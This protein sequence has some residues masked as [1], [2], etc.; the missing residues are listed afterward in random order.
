MVGLLLPN[1]WQFIEAYLAI[2]KLGHIAMPLD[3]T[4]KRLEIEAVL[5]Q[6]PAELIITDDSYSGLLTKFQSKVILFGDMGQTSDAK[7]KDYKALRLPAGQQIAS[8]VFTSGTTGQPK[9][10]PYTHRNHIWNIEVCSK[11]WNWTADDSLLISLPLSHWYGIVMGLSGIIYHGNSLYLQDWFDEQKTLRAL[12]SGQITM[13]T[14]IATIYSLLVTAE[15]D[16]DLS[17]VRLCISGGAALPP[18]VWQQFKDRFGQAILECY[19]SSE[20]G[21]IASNL[22]NERIPGSPGRVLDGVDLKLGPEGE[23]TI[24]SEGVFPGYWQNQSATK[25]AYTADGHWRTG[26]IGQFENGRIILKGRI[27]ERIRRFGYT[28]SPRDVEWALHQS[29]GIQEVYV[30]GVQHPDQANDELVYFVKADL[31]TT[32]ILDY[33]H[34]NLPF[35]WRTENIILVDS[36]PRTKNSKPKLGE[37]NKMAKEYLGA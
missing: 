29:P 26:D 16:Y 10:A 24:K 20:T 12:A 5:N 34:S 35:A 33:V 36:I 31:D 6:I 28:I 25:A 1:S 8:L 17:A 7:T 22:L 4:F 21:R 19:G 27:Q 32:Q 2:L 30:L 14:H 18:P 13:F 15:G 9:A 11:I 23:V 3:P 37:L